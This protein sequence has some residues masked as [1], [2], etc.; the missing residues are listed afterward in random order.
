M[1]SCPRRVLHTN[2]LLQS[3]H[4]LPESVTSAHYPA[5][6]TF[7]VLVATIWGENDLSAGHYGCTS[8]DQNAK[9]SVLTV[10]W[11]DPCCHFLHHNWLKGQ[12]NQLLT[13]FCPCRFLFSV[14]KK[15]RRRQG[16]DVMLYGVNKTKQER[17][18]AKTPSPCTQYCSEII[19][20]CCHHL[21]HC[22]LLRL[23]KHVTGHTG[24]RPTMKEGG[25]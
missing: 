4:C 7:R 5:C 25:S 17:R 1:N 12:K 22:L 11:T 10:V 2:V 8:S 16:S 23:W 21:W 19:T 3:C 15:E 6:N 24:A 20:F 18:K 13:G 14:V 9:R